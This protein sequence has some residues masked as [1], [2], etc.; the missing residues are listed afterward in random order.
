MA[1][2][3]AMKLLHHAELHDVLFQQG[4]ILRLGFV[5]GIDLSRPLLEIELIALGHP[6]VLC[7][8]SSPSFERDC[9]SSPILGYLAPFDIE[10]GGVLAS[11][12]G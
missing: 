6:K 11:L 12:P 1:V 9:R 7:V 5:N 4:L 3:R 8:F 2:G 10:S